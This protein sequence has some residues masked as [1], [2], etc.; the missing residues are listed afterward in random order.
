MREQCINLI[1]DG[2]AVTV[3]SQDGTVS[4]GAMKNIEMA[5]KKLR[6]KCILTPSDTLTTKNIK[7]K[8]K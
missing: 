4:K 5:V 6:E 8:M 3:R 7:E 1:I 2:V